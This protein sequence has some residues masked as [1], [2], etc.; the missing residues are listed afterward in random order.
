[1][2]FQNIAHHVWLSLFPWLVGTFLGGVAGFGLSSLL[3]YTWQKAGS[4]RDCLIMIPWRTGLMFS[5]MMIYSPLILSWLGLGDPAGL[6][7]NT[8]TLFLLS[9]PMAAGIYIWNRGHRTVLDR[10]ASGA[11][12]LAVLSVVTAMTAG[13]YSGGGGLGVVFREQMLSSQYTLWESTVLNVTAVALVVDLVLG[14]LHRL[15][16][17]ARGMG[18]P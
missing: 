14:I 4:F 12:T 9:F 5:L 13:A 10:L 17:R 3:K 8:L 16:F 2:S 15:S 11:R 18:Q 1:M 6:F 7:I